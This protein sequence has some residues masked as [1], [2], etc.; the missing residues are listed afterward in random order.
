MERNQA[1]TKTTAE[2]SA[3]PRARV[4]TQSSFIE[5]R[6]SCLS[7]SVLP[8]GLPSGKQCDLGVIKGDMALPKPSAAGMSAPVPTM[9]GWELDLNG[10]AQ[11]SARSG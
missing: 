6:G 5:A 7:I 10:S 9:L 8:C 4:T 11:S 3:D 2:A 1:V